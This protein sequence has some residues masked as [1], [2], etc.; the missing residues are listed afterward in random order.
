MK[1]K[2]LYIVIALVVILA[3]VAIFYSSSS[4]KPVSP[5]PASL[6]VSS[7]DLAKGTDAASKRSDQNGTV[8]GQAESLNTIVY[9]DSGFSP[10]SITVKVG[11]TVMFKNDSA[12]GMWVA[13][14][15]HPVHTDYPEFDAKKIYNKGEIYSFTF[16]KVGTWKFHNHV[17]PSHFGSVTVQ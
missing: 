6:N 15:P 14:A 9:S 3:G 4:G 12:G 11:D 1:G 8:S 13:S 5:N 2:N 10:G 16:Q 17:K 7:S